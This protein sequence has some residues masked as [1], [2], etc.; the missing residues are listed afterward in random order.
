MRMFSID[1]LFESVTNPTSIGPGEPGLRHGTERET[2]RKGE[3]DVYCLTYRR[4]ATALLREERKQ[5]LR[6]E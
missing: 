5:E 4:N 3:S 1:L 2:E 6:A